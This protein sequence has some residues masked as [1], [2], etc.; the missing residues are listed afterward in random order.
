MSANLKQGRRV[1]L[2]ALALV[3]GGCATSSTVGTSESDTVVSTTEMST[4]AAPSTTNTTAAR[5]PETSAAE[6][7]PGVLAGDPTQVTG[8][9]EVGIKPCGVVGGAGRIWVSI[10]GSGTVRSVDPQTLELSE[11]ISVGTSPCGVAVGA[12]SLWVENYGSNNVTRID[13]STGKVLSTID[14]G[15][16]PYDVTFFDNAA[17]VTDYGDGTVS[18][19]DATTEKRTVIPV[20]PQPIG[21]VAAG[22]M[23][24]VAHENGDLLGID[25]TTSAV[26]IQTS[27][28]TAANWTAADGNDLWIG[29]RFDNDVVHLDATTAKVLDRYDIG[30]LPLDGDVIDGV[31][32]FPDRAGKIHELTSDPSGRVIDSGVGWPFVI[33]GY[34]GSIWAPDYAGT[35]LVRIDPS[36]TP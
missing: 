3:F 34:D 10:F 9:V 18:R 27:I 7:G 29:G 20:S 2:V 11:P 16:L 32:W 26:T 23:V 35:D 36:A 30:A 28:G 15:S 13:L 31:A 33:A 19:I 17:W 25:P 4:T 1:V 8:R 12:D 5:T 6:R 14:V 22:G 21:I 24:W